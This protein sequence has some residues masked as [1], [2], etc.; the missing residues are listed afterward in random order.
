MKQ[1]FLVLLICC[2]FFAIA[3]EPSSQYDTLLIETNYN[4]KNIFFRNQFHSSKGVA[5]LA[6]K[7][8]KVNGEIIQSEINQSVFEIPISNKKRGDKLNIELIYVRGKKPEILNYK[9]I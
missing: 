9:S 6:T 8:V 4:G 5:G 1:I 7:E 2:S 3:K